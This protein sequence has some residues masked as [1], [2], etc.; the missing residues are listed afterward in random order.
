MDEAKKQ[1]AKKPGNLLLNYGGGFNI[2]VKLSGCE[3]SCRKY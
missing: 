3:N 2:A 1:V